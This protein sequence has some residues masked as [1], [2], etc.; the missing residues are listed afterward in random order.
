MSPTVSAHLDDGDFHLLRV[1]GAMR[2]KRLLICL[3]QDMGDHLDRAA[4]VLPRLCLF[5]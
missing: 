1:E 2:V 3:Q 5:L 4:C